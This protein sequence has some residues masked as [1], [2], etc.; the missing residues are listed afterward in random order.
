[1]AMT[2]VTGDTNG[3]SGTMNGASI[4]GITMTTIERNPRVAKRYSAA[5]RERRHMHMPSIN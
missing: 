3:E 1:M 5:P 4:I 2:I